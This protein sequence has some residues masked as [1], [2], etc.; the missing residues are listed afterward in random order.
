MYSIDYLSAK[1]DQQLKNK[2]E[3]FYSES[4]RPKLL[5]IFTPR[6]INDEVLLK[7]F[8]FLV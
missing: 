6:M 7:Y 4:Y 5:E 3:N 8:E 1:T 2:L